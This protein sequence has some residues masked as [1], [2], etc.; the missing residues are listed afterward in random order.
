MD[1]KDLRLLQLLYHTAQMSD[2]SRRDLGD[3]LT[4]IQAPTIPVHEK[5]HRPHPMN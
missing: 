3:L 1:P 2:E 5:R 4:R